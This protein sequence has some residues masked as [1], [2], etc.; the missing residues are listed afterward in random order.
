MS[1]SPESNPLVDEL[2]G[3]TL[4]GT[5]VR[6]EPL[7]VDHAADLLDA[8]QAE[9]FVAEWNPVPQTIEAM[10]RYIRAAVTARAT[11]EQ[12]P[13]AV[14]LLRTGALVGSTRFYE[15]KRWA[16]PHTGAVEERPGSAS[17]GF[18]WLVPSAQRTGVNREMKRLMLE[19]AFGMWG[20]HA[21]RW[22]AD[23][24]NGPSR[25]AIAA[26]GATFDGKL[27]AE[28]WAVDGTVRD[29][30]VYTMTVADWKTIQATGREG[31]RTLEG[32]VFVNATSTDPAARC[33][34][35]E[36][37]DGTI[38]ATYSGDGVRLGHVVGIREEDDLT[39]RFLHLGDD[40]VWLSGSGSGVLVTEADGRGR[41]EEQWQLD[42]DGDTPIVGESVLIERT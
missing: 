9:R 8:V 13:F 36:H 5:L 20:A 3:L 10:E 37:P 42:S 18:T 32:R 15:I 38:S 31:Y 40:G 1:T 4:E 30:V 2:A 24:R 12:C 11:G 14:R 35:R 21:I 28:R 29:T 6:L 39:F 22:H 25:R 26:L 19:H 23:V 27:P 33:E 41:I 7:S 17:I 34:Y 16:D